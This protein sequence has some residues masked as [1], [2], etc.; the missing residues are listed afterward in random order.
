MASVGEVKGALDA[1]VLKIEEAQEVLHNA[2]A[3]LDEAQNMT[4]AA[5]EG[6]GDVAGVGGHIELAKV[7]IIESVMVKLEA[8]KE[9][10]HA[11]QAAL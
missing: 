7:Q 3:L 10:N 11:Y 6:S 4:M 2:M 8:A 9:A 1:A 5:L